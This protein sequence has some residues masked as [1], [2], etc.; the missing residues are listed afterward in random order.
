MKL[1]QSSIIGG[2]STMTDAESTQEVE[3]RA[4]KSTTVGQLLSAKRTTSSST[5]NQKKRQRNQS[6]SESDDSEN[7]TVVPPPKRCKSDKDV[8]LDFLTIDPKTITFENWIWNSDEAKSYIPLYWHHQKQ[9]NEYKIIADKCP[10]SKEVV[11]LRYDP[12][13]DRTEFEK[14]QKY[15]DE[16]RMKH[17]SDDDFNPYE[18][19]KEEIEKEIIASPEKFKLVDMTAK[20]STSLTTSLK[21]AYHIKSNN[22]PG[23]TTS[24]RDNESGEKVNCFIEHYK[25]YELV[26]I[27]TEEDHLEYKRK[28]YADKT[29]PPE[30]PPENPHTG[31]F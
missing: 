26:R 15:S 3:I 12:I 21:K 19:K 17:Y 18:C 16:Q 14:L 25:Y 22:E 6:E 23:E 13:F 24:Q 29:N 10:R 31:I 27:V 20:D 28:L 9:D 7:E 4:K 2:G 1:N 5:T 30:N 8:Q 11:L